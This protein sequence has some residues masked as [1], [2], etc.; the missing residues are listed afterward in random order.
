MIRAERD[1]GLCR[2]TGGK[3]GENRGQTGR[4]PRIL[5]QSKLSLLCLRSSGDFFG[6]PPFFGARLRSI[7]FSRAATNSCVPSGLPVCVHCRMASS[8]A[9]ASGA[10]RNSRQA[11]WFQFCCQK[12]IS[13]MA[14]GGVVPQ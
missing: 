5:L 6:R 1:V 3:T 7:I 2:K 4:F 11:E 12:F 8:S 13:K 14:L 9:V 10:R